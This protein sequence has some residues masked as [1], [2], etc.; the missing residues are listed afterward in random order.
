MRIKDIKSHPQ[1]WHIHKEIYYNE[2][3]CLDNEVRE[4]I[5]NNPESNDARRFNT[6]VNRLVSSRIKESHYDA[7]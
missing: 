1:Y 2:F 3:D 5:Q 7:S 4:S 6:R